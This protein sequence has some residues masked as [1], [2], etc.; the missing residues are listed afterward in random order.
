MDSAEPTMSRPCRI[1]AALRLDHRLKSFVVAG[2]WL[3]K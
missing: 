1:S 3:E 2:P